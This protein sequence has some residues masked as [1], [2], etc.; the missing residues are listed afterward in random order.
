MSV[1][2]ALLF[3][4][5]PMLLTLGRTFATVLLPYRRPRT[6]PTVF[7]EVC[8]RLTAPSESLMRHYNAWC[9]CPP[10]GHKGVV[11]PHLFTQ[12]ALP[13]WAVQ[14]QMTRYPLMTIIN[15][16]C[17]VTVHQ[18]IPA[19]L[20]LVVRSKVV[21][22]SETS[23]RAR[24]H[25]RLTVGTDTCA[26]AWSVDFHTAFILGRRPSQK[27]VQ[28]EASDPLKPLGHWQADRTDGLRFGVL[29][30]DL[31]PIHWCGPIARRSPFKGIILQGFG[32]FTR[33]F[34]ALRTFTGEP[35]HAIDVRFIRPV[36][37][38]S[39]RLTLL[40]SAYM[41]DDGRRALALRNAAGKV[42]MTGWYR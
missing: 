34:E 4:N 7:P 9:G 42:V 30:G 25:Q 16:G 27:R 22:V 18:P 40:H 41:D 38:P 1:P 17:G 35:I 12:F 15:Q 31:N 19:G 11:P 32:L 26:C 24:I 2:A 5:S 10:Q 3:Q 20:D 37:L 33:S 29:T 23:H 21:A 39:G 13:V 28:P 36:S 6:N 8:K 14:L